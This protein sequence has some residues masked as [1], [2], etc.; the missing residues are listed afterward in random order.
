[1]FKM[2]NFHSCGVIK[3]KY[4][5]SVVNNKNKEFLFFH[6]HL[7]MRIRLCS[8]VH[9]LFPMKSVLESSHFLSSRVIIFGYVLMSLPACYL[10][11]LVDKHSLLIH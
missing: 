10:D 11:A 7:K 6:G 2:F 9:D 3:Y 1:M 8:F 4:S 5:L